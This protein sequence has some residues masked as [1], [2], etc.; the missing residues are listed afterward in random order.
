MKAQGIMVDYVP[1]LSAALTGAYNGSRAYD[2]A[3][4]SSN[5]VML[6]DPCHLIIFLSWVSVSVS[7]SY[8]P[9]EGGG[10][11]LPL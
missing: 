7:V 11:S 6:V 8:F 3:L 4:Q 5:E 10:G 2:N 1:N 9:G